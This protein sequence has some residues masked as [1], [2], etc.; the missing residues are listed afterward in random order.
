MTSDPG[1]IP[2]PDPERLFDLARLLG[3]RSHDIVEHVAGCGD[4]RGVL[5]VVGATREAVSPASDPTEAELDA[6]V[7]DVLR[8]EGAFSGAVP[9]LAASHRQSWRLGLVSASSLCAAV[10]GFV[11]ALTAAGAAGGDG[12]PLLQALLIAGLVA[13]LPVM[14]HF[15]GA[16]AL[17]RESRS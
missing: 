6:A 16:T 17:A 1:T 9:D 8:R 10:I 14:H 15:Y 11:V 5:A 13:A 2:H 3:S 4:C 12:R 7:L